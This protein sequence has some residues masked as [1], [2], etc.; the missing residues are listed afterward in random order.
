MTNTNFA[1]LIEAINATAGMIGDDHTRGGNIKVAGVA[2]MTN[3]DQLIPVPLLDDAYFSLNELYMR[4]GKA[5]V[6][7][8]SVGG[9][10]HK[11]RDTLEQAVLKFNEE[12]AGAVFTP[13]FLVDVHLFNHGKLQ[14]TNLVSEEKLV[15]LKARAAQARA[16]WKTT[17]EARKAS[18]VTFVKP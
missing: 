2:L 1:A 8:A 10:V 3:G 7:C 17:R 15:E 14:K 6:T 12:Q 9:V 16:E 11:N 18:L 4:D 13:N 5:A